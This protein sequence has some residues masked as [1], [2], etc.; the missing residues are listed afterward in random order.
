MQSSPVTVTSPRVLALAHSRSSRHPT[1]I[2]SYSSA[3]DISGIYSWGGT[4]LTL[5]V[6]GTWMGT[7]PSPLSLSPPMQG[8]ACLGP[9]NISLQGR[10]SCCCLHFW[11]GHAGRPPAPQALLPTE[12]SLPYPNQA[13]PGDGTV[14]APLSPGRFGT[15]DCCATEHRVTQQQEQRSALHLPAPCMQRVVPGLSA[16]A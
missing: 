14:L 11:G 5:S 7:L 15:G 4:L 9:G 13:A 2:A 3:W 1:K 6:P 16:T 10:D 12:C 8:L